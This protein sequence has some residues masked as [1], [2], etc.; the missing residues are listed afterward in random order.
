MSRM[1]RIIEIH[2]RSLYLLTRGDVHIGASEQDSDLVCQAGATWD[3]INATLEEKGMPLFF[4]VR[5]FV[6]M[7]SQTHDIPA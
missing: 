7:T 3:G 4:P 5:P 1:D 2:G 6:Q